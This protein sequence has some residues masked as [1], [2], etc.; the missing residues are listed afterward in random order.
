[1][2]TIVQI[3]RLVLKQ[4]IRVSEHGYDELANDELTAREVVAGLVDAVV[5]EDY[6]DY[7]KGASVLLLQ[8]DRSGKPIHTVWGIPKGHTSPAVL[9]TAYRP[10]PQRWEH[11]FMKRKPR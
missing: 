3:Q 1:M 5:V 8:R 9:V 4:E 2:S 10:D 7:P 6:P 11:H